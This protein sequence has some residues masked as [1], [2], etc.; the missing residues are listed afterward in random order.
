MELYGYGQAV[1][2]LVW[3]RDDKT[4][5]LL[6]GMVELRPAELPH[7]A[8]SSEKKARSGTKGRTYLYY[9]RFAYSVDAAISWYKAA[10]TGNPVLPA[11]PE[12]PKPG[13]GVSLQGGSFVEEPPWP[14][15]VASNDLGFAPDWMQG[16]RVHFLFPKS[17]LSQKI[18]EIIRNDKIQKKLLEWLNFDIVDTYPEY[19]GAICLVAPNPL[20]RSIEKSNLDLAHPGCAESVAYK[21]VARQGQCLDGLRLE[22]INERPRGRMR[23]FV[24][25]FGAE[26]IAVF[27]SQAEVYKEVLSVT[28]PDHEL[29]SWHEPLPILRT[30]HISME[31]RRRRKSVQVPALGRRRPVYEYEVDEVEDAGKVIAGDELDNKPIVSR[32]TEADNLRSRRE[33]CESLRSEM[34]P[35]RPCR[36]TTL[37]KAENR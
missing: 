34:V 29:L 19:Q 25:E 15:L 11:D 36:S 32:M 14:G 10:L 4:R 23:P 6:F 16:A 8:S 3:F 9:R 13:E 31:V 27:D 5:Y 26:A 20:F 30:M 33:A 22:V 1:I 12:H 2:H 18:V 7:I 17:I 35:R 24:H 37:C 21:I 28:H